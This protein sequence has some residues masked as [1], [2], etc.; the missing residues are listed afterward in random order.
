MNSVTWQCINTMHGCLLHQEKCLMSFFFGSFLFI[1]RTLK[2]NGSLIKGV[3]REFFISKSFGV[4]KPIRSLSIGCNT[5]VNF[6]TFTMTHLAVW[7]KSCH[8]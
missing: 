6:F 3:A 1:G 2:M 8:S 7:N 5:Q 4:S